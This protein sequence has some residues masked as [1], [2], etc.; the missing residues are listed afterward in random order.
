MRRPRQLPEQSWCLH[1][2]AGYFQLLLV[3]HIVHYAESLV[4][5]G[6]SEN[7]N[8]YPQDGVLRSLDQFARA[9]VTMRHSE[10]H[11]TGGRQSNI[12]SDVGYQP[13]IIQREAPTAYKPCKWKLR[14]GAVK[15]ITDHIEHNICTSNVTALSK[16]TSSPRSKE[17]SESQPLPRPVCVPPS[18]SSRGHDDREGER[19][20][21][22][23][24]CSD[25][26]LAGE[27]C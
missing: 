27:S 6:L 9:L 20:S 13:C 7:S 24:P 1:C 4:P 23:D 19:V 10:S 14:N 5:S 15:K 17:T 12:A 26:W 11:S 18:R 2:S 25:C 3:C 22:A 8:S 21:P 16:S